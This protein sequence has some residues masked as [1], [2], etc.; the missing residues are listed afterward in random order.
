MG[1][2]V[3]RDAVHACVGGCYSSHH[4]DN[5]GI[6]Y[7]WAFKV[8]SVIINMSHWHLGQAW[9]SLKHTLM[10]TCLHIQYTIPNLHT[11]DLNYL[12]S[13]IAATPPPHTHT[14]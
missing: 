2:C 1:G 6:F 12:N 5:Y 8:E 3:C 13:L 11:G 4:L 14:L 9:N 7:R 10:Q